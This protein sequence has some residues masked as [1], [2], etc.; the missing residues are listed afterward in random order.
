M[1]GEAEERLGLGNDRHRRQMEEIPV[2]DPQQGRE[3]RQIGAEIGRQDMP[4]HFMGP[5]QNLQKAVES[6]RKT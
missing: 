5:A 6:Q 3:K 1:R 4:V 2:P